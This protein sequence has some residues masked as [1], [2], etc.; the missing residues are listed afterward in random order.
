ME[1]QGTSPIHSAS[2]VAMI[3]GGYTWYIHRLEKHDLQ[4]DLVQKKQVFGKRIGK[5]NMEGCQV[6]FVIFVKISFRLHPLIGFG[7]LLPDVTIEKGN[8]L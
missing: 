6:N 5:N 1:N 7:F 8:T 2:S 3:T 4:N